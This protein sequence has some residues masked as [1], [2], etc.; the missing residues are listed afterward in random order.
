M[1]AQHHAQMDTKGKTS[2][3]ISQPCTKM[4][5]QILRHSLNRICVHANALA[6]L[7]T[8]PWSNTVALVPL[9]SL[10]LLHFGLPE[11]AAVDHP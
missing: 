10:L 8:H 1:A 9:E 3:G 11:L 7:Q 5:R 6:S 4:T 2:R